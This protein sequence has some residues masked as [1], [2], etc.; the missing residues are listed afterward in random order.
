MDIADRPE[1]NRFMGEEDGHVAQLVY[2][3]RGDRLALTHTRVDEELGGRGLGGALVRAAVERAERT[4]E[5][6]VPECPF[7]A[8]WLRRHADVAERV[9]IDWPPED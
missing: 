7:T 8:S 1:Q 6:L 9:A 4:G 2:E 5:T 3:V